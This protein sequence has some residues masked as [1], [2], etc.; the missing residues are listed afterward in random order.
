VLIVTNASN[1]RSNIMFELATTEEI[2]KL[3]RTSGRVSS[4]EEARFTDEI[5]LGEVDNAKFHNTNIF[6][7]MLTKHCTLKGKWFSCK[8]GS[9]SCSWLAP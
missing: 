4:S 8:N 9:K 5:D 3:G 1:V 7:R 2:D 6:Y